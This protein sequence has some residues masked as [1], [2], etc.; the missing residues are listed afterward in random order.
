[1]YCRHEMLPEP[2]KL[3]SDE[4]KQTQK[5]MHCRDEMLPEPHKLV[6]DEAKPRPKTKTNAL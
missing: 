2:R 5:L 1:M 4:A 3:V 6:L